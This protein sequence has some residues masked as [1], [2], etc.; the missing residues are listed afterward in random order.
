[1]KIILGFLIVPFL[2][3]FA[4]SQ[5][6]LINSGSQWKYFDQGNINNSTWNELSY[7]DNAWE[8]GNA[9]FG[10]GDGD[11]ST[12]VGYGPDGNNKYITTYFRKVITV[13]NTQQFSHLNLSLLRDDGAVVYVNGQ[14]VWRS[15]MPNGII[16]YNTVADGTVA[17][18]NEDDWYTTSISSSYLVNGSNVIAVEIHQENNSSSD[19]SFDFSM[20]VQTN[21]SAIVVRGPYLQKVNQ[22]SVIVRWKTNVPTDSRVDYGIST[23]NLNNTFTNPVFSTNHEVHINGLNAASTYFYGVGHYSSL[24]QQSANMYFETMPIN[25]EPGNYEFLVLGDC[26]TGYQEQIDVKNA[27]MSS[28]GNHFDGVLLLGDNAYQSGF[29]SEYETNFFSKYTEIFENTVIWPAPGNHDYNNHIPFSPSP[30][31]FEVFNVPTNAE[32]GGVPTGTEKYYSFE[33]GNI[34][35]I[36]LDSYDEPRSA[37]AQMATWLQ[38]DLTANTK[39]WTVAYWHHPPYTKGSHDSDNDNFLDG[40]L[41]EMRQEILPIL[42]QHGVDLIFNGHSHSYERSMLI[43]GHYGD[44]DSFGSIHKVDEGSGKYP[45][46]CPYQKD[47]NEDE[48][49]N[50]AIYCVMGNSGKISGTDSEWP[51][52]VMYS[53]TASEVGAIILSVNDN[54]L[55]AKFHTGNNTVFDQFSIVKTNGL[56]HDVEACVGD[57]VVFEPSWN[58]DVPSI[59]TPGNTT[60]NTYSI[61]ALANGTIIRTDAN[62]CIPDTFNLI[63]L[64]N[65]TCGY[66][67]LE[68]VT[69]NEKLFDANYLNGQLNIFNVDQSIESFVVFDNFSR[70][71]AEL[72]YLGNSLSVSFEE[73]PSGIYY[74]Q[75]NRSQISKKINKYD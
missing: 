67:E 10:Y 42:E 24:I 33:Y 49:H 18:P 28:Y 21:L 43:D 39:L 1:V 5:T 69:S 68:E 3:A 44:S 31:Y 53:Y 59:W 4:L 58:V 61:T 34:H 11:E 19:I 72:K 51:H 60:S 75:S 36:S 45:T 25:G 22:N 52:P 40:E 7:N 62:G 29:D 56:N 64:Q 65:D 17:W 71:V 8:F 63:V 55:N 2:A 50:G 46:D 20:I 38:A 9:E 74:I 35:F 16:N 27:V 14:E 12:V 48:S 6:S 30:A 47:M 73:Y 57:F 37:T 26:G 54:R 41:V 32:A 66:L 70:I 23:V 15:N 13:N